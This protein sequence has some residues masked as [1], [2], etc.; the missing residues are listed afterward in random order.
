MAGSGDPFGAK[1]ATTL[2]RVTAWKSRKSYLELA[3]WDDNGATAANGASDTQ[4]KMCCAVST[5]VY[6]DLGTMFGGIVV[7]YG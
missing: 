6:N 3:Y 5:L 7:G 2:K 1:W 4:T